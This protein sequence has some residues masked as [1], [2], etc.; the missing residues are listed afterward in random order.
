MANRKVIGASFSADE[1]AEF[2]RQRAVAF[3]VDAQ[4]EPL[5]TPSGFLKTLWQRFGDEVAQRHA[6]SAAEDQ[7]S[8]TKVA[9]LVR[10]LDELRDAINE[11]SKQTRA[12]GVNASQIARFFNVLQMRM[13]ESNAVALQDVSDGL[14][15][16]RG[17]LR[18]VNGLVEDVSDDAVLGDHVARLIDEI[19]FGDRA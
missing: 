16:T 8:L 4:G 12:I 2:E 15:A 7:S 11:R 3:G 14:A 1:L 18:H 17:V 13:G 6:D 10:A 19:R 9:D 5:G